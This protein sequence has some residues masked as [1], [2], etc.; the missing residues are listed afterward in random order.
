MENTMSKSIR[1]TTLAVAAFILAVLP[2]DWVTAAE[3]ARPKRQ[4]S[5]RPYAAA[6]VRRETPIAYRY[7]AYYGPADYGPYDPYRPYYY[8]YPYAAEPFPFG[9]WWW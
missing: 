2:L 1:Y 7:N 9:F 6:I 8:R 5:V 3:L 4:H